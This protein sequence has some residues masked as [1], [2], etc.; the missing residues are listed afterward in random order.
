M[1]IHRLIEEIYEEMVGWRRKLHE[2]PELSFE[3]HQTAAFIYDK[4]AEFKLDRVDYVCETAV[5]ALLNGG[6]GA[7]KS[8]VISLGHHG[9]NQDGSHGCNGCCAGTGYGCKKQGCHN[10]HVSK[11][12]VNWS[13]DTVR[14]VNQAFGNAAF[15]HDSTCQHK[16]GDGKKGKLLD[17]CLHHGGDNA[18]GRP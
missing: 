7:G 9:G 5:V 15:I 13:D 16:E 11:T 6:K 2:E 1:E 18:Q 3:E 14:Q 4:L 17:R 8:C 10:R 12:S